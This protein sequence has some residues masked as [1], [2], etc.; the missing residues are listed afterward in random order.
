MTRGNIVL[1]L[2]LALATTPAW[3]AKASKNQV[4]ELNVTVT[5]SESTSIANGN[6]NLGACDQVNYSAYCRHAAI[7]F[8][9]NRMLVE[10]QDKVF[11]ITCT[12]RDQ[13]S[14]CMSFPVGDTLKAHLDKHGLLISYLGADGKEHKQLYEILYSGAT[15]HASSSGSEGAPPAPR[16]DE[17]AKDHARVVSAAAVPLGSGRVDVLPAGKMVAASA[18]VRCSFKSQPAGAEI[19]LDGKYVGNTP[20]EVSLAPGAHQIE[21]SMSGFAS[22]HRTLEAFPGS[23][24][25][26]S[27]TLASNRP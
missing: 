11:N 5:K 3:S 7:E 2:G 19:T 8:T 12:V 21:M 25:S 17:T 10:T 16:A 20:S 15:L 23:D 26:V 13:W 27:A 24:L 9:Q 1:V 4:Y 14:K 18:N 6:P 22:W